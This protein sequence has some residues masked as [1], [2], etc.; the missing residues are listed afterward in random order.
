MKRFYFPLRC[1]VVLA[2]AAL[3]PAQTFTTLY[4][5]TGSDGA[6]PFAG[7]VRDKAGK[8]YGTTQQGGRHGYGVLYKLNAAGTETV[9]Y[10][11]CSQAYCADGK[12]PENS[13]VR[14]DKGNLYGTADGGDHDS[15]V[16]FRIDTAGNETVLYS[17]AGGSD[18]CGPA[19]GLLR[20]KAGN[21]YGTT[22]LCGSTNQGTIFK[23][24]RAGNFSLLHSFA[25][26]PSDGA[27]PISGHLTMDTKGNLY[28][29]TWDGGAY[30]NGAL[31]KL[32]KKGTLTLLYSFKPTGGFICGAAGTVVRDKNGNLYGTTQY[33]GS[34]GGSSLWKVSKKGKETI[35]HDFSSSDGC[36]PAGVTRD[37]K[38]NLYGATYACG[39]N[40]YGTL[41]ELRAGGT[42]TV[43]YRW[44]S[45]DGHP[46][47]DL[48][49]TNKGKLF[50]TTSGSGCCSNYGTAWSYVP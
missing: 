19:Q 29:V 46:N 23:I 38:G 39:D 17:F 7:V 18:G 42:F 25:G 37:S 2:L 14:D 47:G 32:S 4:S 50:G 24:D 45:G 49:V 40:D 1:L 16:V 28:G 11:F 6:S 9:L 21:L 20:D 3:A 26:S 15:G 36:W 22:Q 30:Q 31:Y 33:C 44:N 34:N 13:L 10:S 5:F 35:V 12:F 27:S 41:W 48:W 8:L 43:L